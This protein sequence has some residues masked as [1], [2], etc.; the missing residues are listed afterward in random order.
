MTG[1]RF[2]F[3]YVYKSIPVMDDKF[4]TMIVWLTTHLLTVLAMTAKYFVESKVPI[5]QKICTGTWTEDH[6][7]L[8]GVPVV[9]YTVIICVS[10][11]FTLSIGILKMKMKYKK[12]TT[13]VPFN[14][15]NF[16]KTNLGSL[17][18]SFSMGTLLCFGGA[19]YL[20]LQKSSL[21]NLIEFPNCLMIHVFYTIIP[22][23]LVTVKFG[24]VY[25]TS[26]EVRKGIKRI[27]FPNNPDL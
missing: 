21:Q 15:Q 5:I 3:V 11:H 23:C 27:L 8:R 26:H 12:E 17:A 7:E 22:F 6:P 25:L 16:R 2:A 9:A 13:V 4:I 19:V 10:I 14:H 1:F 24:I 18:M 20:Y